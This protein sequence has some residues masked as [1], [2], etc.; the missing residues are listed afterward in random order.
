MPYT[1]RKGPA[2]SFATAVWDE[3]V[4]HSSSPAAEPIERHSPV[5]VTLV[6]ILPLTINNS[7][8][9]A[10][11]ERPVSGR[12]NDSAFLCEP[13]VDTSHCM[14][15]GRRGSLGDNGPFDLGPPEYMKCDLTH[16][17][18]RVQPALSVS[19]IRRRE[20]GSALLPRS[21]GPDS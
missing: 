18:K 17:A 14:K 11:A 10:R 16:G 20:K 3:C 9:D 1:E 15:T 12:K 7:H 4:R 13:I 21:N 19:Q 5:I 8:R 2:V 6:T